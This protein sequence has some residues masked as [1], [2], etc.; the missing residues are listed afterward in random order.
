MSLGFVAPAEAVQA[1]HAG[2][3][4]CPAGAQGPGGCYTQGASI[5][6]QGLVCLAGFTVC[7][8]TA[9]GSGGCYNPQVAQ[10]VA[11]NIFYY[12][13]PPSAAS[14]PQAVGIPW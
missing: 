7:S 8:R 11:G 13:S 10:C 1:C 6:V 14:K 4:T 9:T 5:C 3:L 2:A 12:M